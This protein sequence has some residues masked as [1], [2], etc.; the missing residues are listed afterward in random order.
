MLLLVLPLQQIYALNIAKSRMKLM[1]VLLFR[2][3]LSFNCNLHLTN[4]L[5]LLKLN[6]DIIAGFVSMLSSFVSCLSS[7]QMCFI[8]QSAPL[9]FSVP[10]YAFLMFFV[11]INLF[12]YF[13]EHVLFFS[14]LGYF[15]PNCAMLISRSLVVYLITNAILIF[16]L[17]C[18]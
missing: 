6:I 14:Q 13:S 12:P 5:A 1:K 10:S 4:M 15:R 9:S 17:S 2:F 3:C 18:S 11:P 7:K 8:S 16:R